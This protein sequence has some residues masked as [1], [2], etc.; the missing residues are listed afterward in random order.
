MT[1]LIQMNDAYL[2]SASKEELEEFCRFFTHVIPVEKG[3]AAVKEVLD[4]EGKVLVEAQEAKGD[5]DKF[6]ACVRLP[7]PVVETDKVKL[8]PV[9]D[10]MKVVG[11]W[12]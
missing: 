8:A 3:Q 4:K 12:A 7:C 10:A 6:Y 11:V 5:P 9:A 1:D 2:E